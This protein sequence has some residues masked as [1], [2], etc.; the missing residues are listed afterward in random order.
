MILFLDFDG[1]LH[2][3]P[4]YDEKSLFCRAPRI[5]SVLRDFPEVLV[6]IS[7]TWRERRSLPEL[8]SFFSSDISNR[9]IGTTPCWKD[10]S[11]LF[12]VI[13][14]QRQ[15]EVEAW[16][17]ES[18]EP[19]QSWIAIDDKAF[20]FKPFLTKLVKTDS[21]VGFDENAERELRKKLVANWK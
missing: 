2:P 10:F 8:K 18:G 16:L 21:S 12:E 5:E 15:T 17:R 19:W 7:S 14:Y 9:I 20:L 3:D 11:D 1:V 4:C 13:R 6:V